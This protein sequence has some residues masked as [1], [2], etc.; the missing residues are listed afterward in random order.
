[1]I[2]VEHW[3]AYTQ[4]RHD[5]FGVFDLL[6]LKGPE[7]MGVQPTTASNVSARVNKITDSPYLDAIRKA[8]WNIQVHGWAK[9]KNRWK[10]TRRVDLS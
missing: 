3:N 10:L 6:A 9:V 4:R 1:M 5:L 2:V 8:G 7:T